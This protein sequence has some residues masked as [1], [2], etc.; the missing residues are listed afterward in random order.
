MKWLFYHIRSYFGFSQ[1]ESKG[2]IL[3]F[4]ILIVIAVSPFIFK[5]Y[6]K[7]Q[8]IKQESNQLDSLIKVLETNLKQK[9]QVYSKTLAENSPI[10]S[11]RKSGFEITPK[12]YEKDS[13]FEFKKDSVPNY[14]RTFLEP[15][16]LNQAD[17]AQLKMIYGIGSV[18]SNRIVKYRNWLGGYI[19]TQQLHEVYGLKEEVLDTL[20]KYSFI[21][22]DFEPE[23]ININSTPAYLLDDHPYMEKAIAKNIENYIRQHGA[24]TGS[25]QLYEI[26]LLDS[27]TINKIIPYLKF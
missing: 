9:K 3:L 26:E 2:V 7:I 6:Y 17:T 1:I 23:R 12:T 27:A 11:T 14:R 22:Q 4:F 10:Q 8:E 16:D 5:T 20:V 15:F 18:L 13:K 19:S 25:S 24:L 21:S